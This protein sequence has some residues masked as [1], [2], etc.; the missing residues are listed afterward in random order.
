MNS[1]LKATFQNSGPQP[2]LAACVLGLALFGGCKKE[3]PGGPR[4]VTIPVTGILTVDGKPQ[5][6][7]AV[8]AEPVSGSTPTNNT[9]SSFSDDEGKFAL[10]TYE[11]GD[12]VPAGEYKL[13]FKWGQ[14]NLFSGR[15]E[16]DKF[17]GKYADP[18][19]SEISIHV[20]ESSEPVD[21]GTIDLTTD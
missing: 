5:A 3:P 17:K 6:Q 4:V 8:R 21:L 20:T 11:S 14:I 12:G 15:Y 7:I 13:T 19:K 10:T 16:G 18:E 1:S 9:P 2:I